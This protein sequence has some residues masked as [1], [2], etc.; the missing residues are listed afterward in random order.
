MKPLHEDQIHAPA[1]QK[2]C[3]YIW[4]E[5]EPRQ[6]EE[7]VKATINPNIKLINDV[8]RP[9]QSGVIFVGLCHLLEDVLTKIPRDGN[10]IVIHRTNDRPFVQRMVDNIPPSVK[11]IYTVDCRGK[12]DNVTAIPFGVSSINGEDEILKDVLNNEPLF[13]TNHRIFCCYNVNSDTLHR[14]ESLPFVKNS[15][16]VKYQE[17]SIGQYDF[18]AMCKSHEFTMA[19]AGCGADASRQWSSMILG[20]IPIVT[21]CPE[22]RHFEDMP[23]VFC[24]PFEQI[25]NEWLD[26]A[27][28]SI[29]GKSTARL[30]MSYWENHINEMKLKHSIQ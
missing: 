25:T 30:R 1:F 6:Y 17:P 3:D 2:L 27:K 4:A 10:Y 16:L 11:H 14:N 7:S 13:Q 8:D 22:M 12:W 15:P 5:K 29:K 9:G 28:E 19:L 26:N 23:L 20:S 21:D 18:H 24:P